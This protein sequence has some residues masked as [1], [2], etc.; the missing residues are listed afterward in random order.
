[1]KTMTSELEQLKIDI[2]QKDKLIKLL[3][4]KIQRIKDKIQELKDLQ[5]QT[6]MS[7]SYKNEIQMLENFLK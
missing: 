1:M 2:Y 7:Y 3:D 6:K 4:S 5:D